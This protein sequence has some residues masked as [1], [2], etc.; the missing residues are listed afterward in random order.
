MSAQDK[1]EIIEALNLY[2]FALNSHQFE[3]FDRVFTDDVRAEFG[4]AG[5]VWSGLANLK[6]TFLEFHDT[7]T[8]HMH[9]MMGHVVH[10]N[11]DKANSF[12]YGNWLLVRE[13]AEGGSSWLG[14]GWYDD[15]LVRTPNGWRIR[16]RIAKLVSWNGNPLVPVPV[17]EHH[18]DMGLNVLS[19]FAASGKIRFF[20]AIKAK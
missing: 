9:Q 11:G 19:K 14:S 5:A 3:L 15:E 16:D 1:A 2:A 13:G 20:E 18:P 12:T 7:L 6:R 4:P 10:V 8:N 17:P